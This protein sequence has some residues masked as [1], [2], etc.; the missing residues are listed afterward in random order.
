MSNPGSF[1]T[2][3]GL[4]TETYDV[5]TA[6]DLAL[7]GLD[8]DVAFYLDEAERAGGPVLELGGGTGRVAWALAEAGFEVDLLDLSPAMIEIA[9]AR[10][11]DKPRAVGDRLRTVLADMTEF[12][13]DRRFRL[14]IAPFRA[15][16]TLLSWEDQRRCLE[17]AWRHLEPGGRVILHLFDP[18]LDLLAREGPPNPDRGSVRHPV[19]GNEVRITVLSRSLDLLRQ[20]FEERWRFV[21]SATD[22]RTLREEEEI[23]RMRLTYRYEMRH[24]LELAGLDVEAEFSDFD[25]SP[26]TYGRE[27]VWLARKP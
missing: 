1:Y 11:P 13:I 22:G 19:T 25:R 17:A 5:R 15:F 23:L 3:P 16:A 4:N 9:E 10:R 21:E 18:R 7:Q 2:E 14:V 27:Q 24:L 12:E 6:R 8:G 26:P 20:V